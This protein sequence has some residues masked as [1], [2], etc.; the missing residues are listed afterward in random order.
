MGDQL[1]FE[2]AGV[3]E[4][5][6]LEALAGWEAGGPDT[7]LAAVGLAGGDFALQAGD[8]ELLVRPGLLTGPFGQPGGP[9]PARWVPS[10]PGSGT[11]PRRSGRGS[12]HA[13]G[14]LV[15][16]PERAVVVGQ[17]ADLHFAGR[18]GRPQQPDPF[19]A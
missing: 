11:R 1:A 19:G 15:G 3:V 4:V 9:P 12:C 8:Q 18:W 16:E 10:E 5:E 13:S 6:L 7:S 17:R 14:S 2:A